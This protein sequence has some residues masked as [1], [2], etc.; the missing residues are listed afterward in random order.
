MRT[1]ARWP[2]LVAAIAT[3]K[4][5]LG[6]AV[7]VV[8]IAGVATTGIGPRYALMLAHVMVF[9]AAAVLLIVGG[10]SDRRAALL[11]TVFLLVSSVFADQLIAPLRNE[12][13]GL[14]TA[15]RA[16]FAIQIDALTPC[17]LWMFVREF[18]RVPE[19]GTVHQRLRLVIRT[20]LAVGLVLIAANAIL[21]FVS[22]SGTLKTLEPALR[23]LSRHDKGGLYWPSQFALSIVALPTLVWR[24]RRAPIDERRRAA[25][26]VAA[27]VAGTAP[28]LLWVFLQGLSTTVAAALP[29]RRIGWLLYPT[30]LSTPFTTA[31][32][33]VVRRA[34]DVTLVI[35]RAVQ[36]ALA[37]YSVM[38]AASVPV[39]VL[40]VSVYRNRDASIAQLLSRPDQIFLGALAAAG[41]FMLRRRSEALELIDRRFFR[42]QYD[43]QRILRELVHRCRLAR[44]LPELAEVIRAEVDRALHLEVV[45]VLFFD[46]SSNAFVS[47]TGDVRPLDVGTHLAELAVGEK[48]AIEVDLQQSSR[49]SRRLPENDLHWLVDGGFTLFLPLRDLDRRTIGILALGEKKSELPFSSEDK[50]LLGAV[51][52]A[53]EVTA[54]ARGVTAVPR[55]GDQPTI[56]PRI[57]ERC[58]AECSACGAVFP[59]DQIVCGRCG[60]R[61]VESILPQTVAGKF[62]IEERIGAGGMGV[63]YRGTD[64]HLGRPVAI[65]TLPFLAPDEALRLRREARAMASVSHPNLALIFG[66]ETWQGRPMLVFEYLAGGTLTDRLADGPLDVSEAVDLGIAMSAV[67]MEIHRAGVLHRD[68]KPSNIG[69]TASGTPKLLDFG[70]A[71]VLTAVATAE[72]SVPRLDHG[73]APAADATP[74]EQWPLMTSNSVIRGTLLYM[75]PEALLGESPAPSFDIWSLCVVLY[76]AIAGRNPLSELGGRGS[77]ALMNGYAFPDIRSLAPTAPGDLGDF[78]RAALSVDVTHRPRTAEHLHNQLWQLRLGARSAEMMARPE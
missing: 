31:Y 23:V 78:F 65:K 50:M 11:G 28:T 17:F 55:E 37:R 54:V 40:V 7:A 71:R 67:L 58:A 22:A 52:A 10:R 19:E 27:L 6:V 14:I 73:M 30:L 64:M 26:L 18:P 9:A 53:A 12:T 36:Y 21:Y 32:A 61:A 66:A 44:N 49:L 4:V 5:G 75:S 60:G 43:S 20:S 57:I 72:M 51:A 62:R 46:R 39:V 16:V 24:A 70:L 38:A 76:E 34:L 13:S 74:D 77:L 33:V 45:A 42:E 47:P 48:D 8:L 35:R 25:L 68:I 59:D 29:L 69:Y 63:V 41:L 2:S 1:A 3:L 15:L 56:A